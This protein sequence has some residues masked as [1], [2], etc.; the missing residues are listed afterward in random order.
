MSIKTSPW[1]K[2]FAACAAA[3]LSAPAFATNGM[4]LIGYGAK[5]VGMGGVGIAYPQ[6]AMATAYNPASITGVGQ[7]RFDGTLELMRAPNRVFHDAGSPLGDADEESRYKLFPIP[8]L[9]AVMSDPYTPLSL[10]F[11]FVGAGLG[12]RFKQSDQHFFDPVGTSPELSARARVGVFLVQMQMLPTF[13]YRFTDNQSVGFSV[14]MAAQTFEATGLSA[15]AGLGY[16]GDPEGLSDQQ[17]DWGYGLGYRVGYFGKFFDQRLNVG[18]NISPRVNMSRFNRYRGLFANNGEFDIPWNAG[19][20]F[21]FKLSND[22]TAAMDVMRV[23]WST[24]DSIGNPGPSVTD[25]L[26]DFNPLCPGPD[27]VSIE[28]KLGGH[29]GMGFGWRDQTIYKFGVDYKMTPKTTLRAGLNYAEAPIPNDQVLFNMLAPAT[30]ESHV[31]F[32]FSSA[33]S[34]KS[35]F[36]FTFMHAFEN[37]I[38]GPTAFPP[39]AG[40]SVQGSNACIVMNQTSFSFAYGLQF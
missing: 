14:V 23:A 36:T 7:T 26:G 4:Y 22:F 24:V 39:T 5:A 19:V 27:D 2:V 20:G 11:G 35:D 37:E 17:L 15:F 9:A 10:G 21:A 13:A 1:G 29:W 12:T 34:D 30:T 16:T 33:L 6:D 38:C 3:A 28:C 31:T 8:A 25:P 40:T 18:V 32:G